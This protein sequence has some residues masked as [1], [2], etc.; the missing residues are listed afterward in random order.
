MPQEEVEALAEAMSWMMTHTEEA[1]EM[2]ERASDYAL[3][4]HSS[5]AHYKKL[6]G[7]YESV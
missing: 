3:E 2:G 4:V 6:I 5:A 7:I 1:R